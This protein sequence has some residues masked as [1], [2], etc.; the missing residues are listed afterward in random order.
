MSIDGMLKITVDTRERHLIEAMA[1]LKVTHETASL[2][3]GDI[4]I[5]SSDEKTIY[6]VIERKTIADL[7][8]SIKDGRYRE[9]QSRL[10]EAREDSPQTIVIY[11][12]EGPPPYPKK[13]E[14]AML[15]I[16]FRHNFQVITSSSVTNSVDLLTQL[17]AKTP[18]WIKDRAEKPADWVPKAR[19]GRIT[20]DECYICMLSSIPHVSP[21]I[22][23]AIQE[24]YPS[25]S[26]L[27][28]SL[29][30]PMTRYQ[31][32]NI[33]VGSRRIG[34]AVAEK[35]VAFLPPYTPPPSPPSP[36]RPA[37][38]PSD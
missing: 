27:L 13:V 33:K 10:S 12:I 31:I 35:L 18:E 6:Y 5:T 23:R 34:P 37:S 1:H 14:S 21:Q 8:A 4:M 38:P 19:K 32:E 28:E 26:K 7:D 30:N 36:S 16:R 25:M 29:R 24:Y 15:S 22:A 3:I 17:V 20:P 11:L 9:Q 2:T